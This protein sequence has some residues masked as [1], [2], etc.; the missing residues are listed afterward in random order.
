MK[1]RAT[2]VCEREGLFLLVAKDRGRWTFP[3]GR[4]RPH[5][6][7]AQAAARELQ[8]ETGLLPPGLRYVFQFRGLRTRHFVFFASVG[9]NDNAVPC[10][11]IARCIWLPLVE[12]GNIEA[13]VPTKGIAELLCRHASLL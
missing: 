1:R 5:E 10:N 13:S 2:V 11:E 12:F 4:K 9:A 6:R 7:F 8:E 3:G